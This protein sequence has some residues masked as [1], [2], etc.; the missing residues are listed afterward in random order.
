MEL[1]Y[2]FYERTVVRVPLFGYDQ[3]L[4][5]LLVAA[6]GGVWD[7]VRQELSSS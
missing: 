6:G 1:V 7:N 5:G 2:F 4:F 3:R